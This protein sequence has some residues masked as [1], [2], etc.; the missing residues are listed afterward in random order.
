MDEKKNIET[1]YIYFLI[2]N[3][4]FKVTFT[5]KTRIYSTLPSRIIIANFKLKLANSLDKSPCVL[6]AIKYYITTSPLLR[7]PSK[8]GGKKSSAYKGIISLSC[9]KFVNLKTNTYHQFSS[10]PSYTPFHIPFLFHSSNRVC[11]LIKYIP[12]AIAYTRDKKLDTMINPGHDLELP[13]ETGEILYIGQHRCQFLGQPI[14]L[15]RTCNG[16]FT[17][18]YETPRPPPPS[19]IRL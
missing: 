15:V 2:P 1:K 8:N 5:K 3:H 16:C 18:L 6:S 10:N 7:N 19:R 4:R 12:P 11:T 14:T 13:V 17:T 9:R